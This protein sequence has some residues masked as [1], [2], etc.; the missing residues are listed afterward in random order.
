M[1]TPSNTRSA[2]LQTRSGTSRIE[3]QAES[4][5]GQIR[6]EPISVWALLKDA[7]NNRNHAAAQPDESFIT[8]RPAP[9][10]A[11]PVQQD[12]VQMDRR[13]AA[14]QEQEAERKKQG[15]MR[16]IGQDLPQIHAMIGSLWGR[17]ECSDYI[18]DLVMT[19]GDGVNPRAPRLKIDALTALLE[20]D[21]L[22]DVHLGQLR[23]AAGIG[24]RPNGSH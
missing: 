7:L 9:L 8:T 4:W 19:G 21:R 16:T 1:T 12:E 5:P 11:M 13:S 17:Q 23:D 3:L 24:R 10:L 18:Q 14:P 22:H 6:R 2:A 15:A 20:L